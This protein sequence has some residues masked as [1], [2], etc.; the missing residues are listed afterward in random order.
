MPAY[1]ISELDVSRIGHYYFNRLP[2]KGEI[3]T[4]GKFL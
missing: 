4:T 3:V 2:Y 1:A